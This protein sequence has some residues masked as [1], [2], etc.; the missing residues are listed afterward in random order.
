MLRD[1]CLTAAGA[2]VCCCCC[3]TPAWGQPASFQGLGAF[4]P[5]NLS[6]FGNDV[7]G[8]GRVVVG[9]LWTNSTTQFAYRWAPAG[10]VE[11]LRSSAVARAASLDG[12]VIV[13]Q[14]F[15][16]DTQQQAGFRWTA[17]GG[18]ERLPMLDATD[19]SEDG[20]VI[21]AY[22]LM[23]RNGVVTNIGGLFATAVSGD[24]STVVGY[25]SIGHPDPNL[26]TRAYRWTESTGQVDLG[27]LAGV[28]AIAEGV[29]TDG[30]VIVGQSRNQGGFW[31]AVR[32]VGAGGPEDLGT[33][34]GTMSAAFDVSGNGAVIVGQSLLTSALGTERAFRWT[35]QTGM[36]DLRQLL[37]EA[38]V[39]EVQAWRSLRAALAVS[40]DGRVIV[41]YGRNP[42]NLWE[43]W[44]AVLPVPGTCPADWNGDGSVTPADVAAFVSAWSADLSAGSA[45]TDFDASGTVT[46][47]DVAAFVSAWFSAVT[48]GGGGC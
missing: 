7:S 10:G 23:W 3:G 36:R 32:W 39:T 5:G 42:D 29:N 48:G 40:K 22:A 20:T 45:A 8:D 24:G 33:L 44:R 34:G 17:A 2:A 35:A 6:S 38:G 21:V 18:M 15:W 41:G 27:S 1:A 12:S 14:A 4:S 31:R 43:A 30:T 19:V 47:A 26:D 13:G 37:M 28:E 46:P 11:M 9:D 16:A 25:Y